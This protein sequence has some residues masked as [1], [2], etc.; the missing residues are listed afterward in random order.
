MNNSIRIFFIICLALFQ[1]PLHIAQ[2]QSSEEL[3]N[4]M[5]DAT[6]NLNYEGTF[7]FTREDKMD[8]M[9]IL[10]KFD[11]NG[12]Q[13]KIVALTGHAREIIRNNETVT[14]F[15]PDT[16]EV[17]VER[18]R[19][20]GLT[21]KIPEAIEAISDYYEFIKIGEDRVAGKD[22][23]IVR[24]TPKDEFRY[25]YQLWIDKESYLLLKSVMHD[26]DGNSLEQVMFT[27]LQL[28]DSIEDE[29]F[30]PSVSG[31]EYKW[32]QYTHEVNYGTEVQPAGLNNWQVTWIPDG[33]TLNVYDGNSTEQE[34]SLLE[35]MIYSD[36]IST[37][38]IFIEK[39]TNK[40]AINSGSMNMGGVNI[41]ST[42]T[43]GF[44]VTAVGEVPQPTVIRIVDS[45]VAT[46]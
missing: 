1:A 5:A 44:Q 33:F 41:Y 25:G 45:V 40:V 12:E 32:Y 31:N 15:Y 29:L 34:P 36:G 37:V 43:N 11:V 3:I 19:P 8:V 38:S 27:E 46:R 9:H 35:H 4:L 16:Q 30:K 10:H 26:E 28:R 20:Q 13:E 18:G 14:C 2:A 22:T 39:I 21:S 17:M 42:T 6:K 7:V 24:I 23:W